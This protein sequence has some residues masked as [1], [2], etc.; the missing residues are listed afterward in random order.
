MSRFHRGIRI[1]AWRASR[2]MASSW[3]RGEQRSRCCKVIDRLVAVSLWLAMLSRTSVLWNLTFQDSK[4]RRSWRILCHSL[5]LACLQT[6]SL[7]ALEDTSQKLPGKMSNGSN[8]LQVFPNAREA[9]VRMLEA[10]HPLQKS[11]TANNQ[12]LCSRRSKINLMQIPIS[13]IYWD[14]LRIEEEWAKEFRNWCH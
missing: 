7:I 12:F 14:N 9:L 13:R 8:W 1:W 4:R 10:M 6:G 2:P 11:H 5:E 3:A